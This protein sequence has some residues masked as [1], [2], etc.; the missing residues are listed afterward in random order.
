MPLETNRIDTLSIKPIRP[1]QL[2]IVDGS[3]D[4]LGSSEEN[5]NKKTE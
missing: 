1:S 5:E 3:P 2:N 4:I